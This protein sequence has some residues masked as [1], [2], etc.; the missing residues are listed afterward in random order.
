MPLARSEERANGT[1]RRSSERHAV[2]SRRGSLAGRYRGGKEQ[3]GE[4][5]QSG[6][7]NV[8]GGALVVLRR[9]G[10]G[11]GRR[12]ARLI[13]A[14]GADKG[15]LV[16]SPTTASCPVGAR[17]SERGSERRHPCVDRATREREKGRGNEREQTLDAG[18]RRTQSGKRSEGERHR[19]IR[20][21]IHR[22]CCVRSSMA[23]TATPS[24][25]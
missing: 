13:S 1:T 10:R 21:T 3:E 19:E 14:A 11:R 6:G 22:C 18:A 5:D 24:S 7:T 23:F 20:S 9:G 2:D 16:Y 8:H 12:S 25:S 15:A 4:K 17:G